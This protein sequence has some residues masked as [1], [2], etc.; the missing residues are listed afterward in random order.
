MV[1]FFLESDNKRLSYN[2]DWSRSSKRTELLHGFIEN[3]LKNKN[4]TLKIE[5]EKVV[6][7]N[8][9]YSKKHDFLINDNKI[10][11]LKFIEK[12]FEKNANNYFEGE[13]G[14]SV[15]A[16]NN[17]K[18]F[19]SMTFIRSSAAS[20]DLNGVKEHFKKYNYLKNK[21]VYFYDDKTKNYTLLVGD[22]YDTLLTK[23]AN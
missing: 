9:N 16:E 13:L 8:N 23:I 15:V 21:S 6:Q 10:L 18:E 17:N 22:D 20:N 4:P 14:R 7:Y 1:D 3:D 12:S 2:G 11:E 19:Y 5:K